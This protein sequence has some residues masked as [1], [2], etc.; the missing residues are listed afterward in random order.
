MAKYVKNNDSVARTWGGMEI[1]SGSYYQLQS[2]EYARWANNSSVMDSIV[3]GTLIVS[4]TGDS[5]G[6]IV[7][8]ITALNYLKDDITEIDSEGRQIVRAA[9]GKKGWSYYA[10]GIQIETSKLGGLYCKDESGTNI[11]G[12][13]IKFYDADNV[14]L[15]TQETIDAGC[16]KT[17]LT[18]APSYDYEIIAGNARQVSA[19]STDV[20]L[21][22][23]GGIL[24][25]GGAYVKSFADSQNLRFT[26]TVP[27]ETD[28]RASKYMTKTIPGVPY[29][30]NQFRFTLKHGVGVKHELLVTLEM[31]RA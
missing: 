14:E 3:D 9:A 19:P 28:G 20:R 15:T 30:G 25:L 7:D 17:I 11:S 12:I 10:L 24:E 23:V 29:Q 13:S 5:S 22:V 21:W 1:E 27:M 8:H 18:I 31:F 26:G 16:V 6:H 2:V 4:K